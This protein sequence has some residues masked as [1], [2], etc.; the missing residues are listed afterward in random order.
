MKRASFSHV[1]HRANPSMKAGSRG[2]TIV[3]LLIV[4]VV[5]AILAAITVVAYNGVSQRSKESASQSAVSQAAKKIQT[6][7]ITNNETF[8]STLDQAGVTS[9]ASTKF[10]YRV[11]TSATP[12]TFCVTAATS[13]VSYFINNTTSPKPTAGACPGHSSNGVTTVTNLAHDP[14]ATTLNNSGNGRW[15]NDRYAAFNSY[16]LLTGMP[17]G[18]AGLT[19]AARLRI[20]A[21]SNVAIGFH[22]SGNTDQLSA[23]VSTA[24]PVGGSMIYT[25]SAYARWTGTSGQTLYLITRFGN[26]AGDWVSNA[27]QFGQ[28]AVTSGVW[29]RISAVVT[30][31]VDAT[32]LT[33][34]LRRGG[35][36]FVPGDTLD[37][38]GLMITEGSTLHN[39][40]YG[41]SSGWTWS[42]GPNNSISSGPAL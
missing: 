3:E 13:N 28:T 23:P 10:Q 2:F 29:Y 39:F 40:G 21:A 22:L 33:L 37:G 30:A 32:N 19:T 27:W 36:A 38:T 41:S 15:A 8:P 35:T 17:D 24:I 20:T 1:E 42:G 12:Q 7:A 31:P 6:F 5:I 11:D 26:N 34:A 16:E 9:S 25:I 18:P 14:A 4:V